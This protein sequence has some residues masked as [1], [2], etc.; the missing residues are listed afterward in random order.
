MKTALSTALDLVL[1]YL[2]S[3]YC[4]YY[5]LPEEDVAGLGVVLGEL[6]NA[7]D[8]YKAKFGKV[9]VLCVDGVDLLAKRHKTMCE[10]LITLAKVLSN[11]KR[12]KLVL[13]SSDGAVMP[14]YSSYPL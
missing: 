4:H 12:L 2:S 1:A 14:F 10:A 6:A 3:S 13:I 5:V 7:A 9:P 11:T 8:V